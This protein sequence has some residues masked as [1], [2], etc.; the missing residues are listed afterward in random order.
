VLAYVLA[1]AITAPLAAWIAHRAACHHDHLAVLRAL[2]APVAVPPVRYGS[3]WH[4]LGLGRRAAIG[5]VLAVA[6]AM[7]GL[8]W[9]LSPVAAAASVFTALA[10]LAAVLGIKSAVRRQQ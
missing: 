2:H 1:G 7:C 6:G 5:I 8:A 10:A 3:W 9:A 4:G